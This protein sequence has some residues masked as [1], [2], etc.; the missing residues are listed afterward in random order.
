M[1]SRYFA[2]SLLLVIISTA[3]LGLVG[4]GDIYAN[5]KVSVSTNVVELYLDDI[6]VDEPLEGEDEDAVTYSKTQVITATIEGATEDMV[7]EVYCRFDDDSVANAD[8]ELN[9][10]EST[11]RLTAKNAGR[12]KMRVVSCETNTVFSEEIEVIVYK[13]AEKMEFLN[14]LPLVELGSTLKLETSSLIAFEP[15]RVYPNEATFTIMTPESELWDARYGSSTPAGVVIE[16]NTLVVGQEAQCGVVQIEASMPNGVKCA[17]LVMVYRDIDT[18]DIQLF[19]K[20]ATP[21][22]GGVYPEVDTLKLTINSDQMNSANL[23]VVVNDAGQVLIT[24]ITTTEDSVIGVDKDYI[25]EPSAVDDMGNFTLNARESGTTKMYVNIDVM[26]PVSRKVYKTFTRSYDVE[27]VRMATHVMLSNQGSVATS[28]PLELILQDYYESQNIRGADVNVVVAPESAKNRNFVINV[29][30]LDGLTDADAGFAEKLENL[31]IYVNSRNYVNVQETSNFNKYIYG[32]LLRNDTTFYVALT[33]DQIKSSVTLAMVANTYDPSLPQN[34]QNTVHF[35]VT[36]GVTEIKL[37]DELE[38]IELGIGDNAFFAFDFTTSAGENVGNP[39]FEVVVKDSDIATITKDVENERSYI[40]TALKEGSTSVTIMAESGVTVTIPLYVYGELT[41]FYISAEHSYQNSNIALDSW[42]SDIYVNSDGLLDAGVTAMTVKQGSKID[43]AC[44]VAPESDAPDYIAISIDT[45]DDGSFIRLS[46]LTDANTFYFRALNPTIAPVEIVVKFEYNKKNPNGT[47]TKAQSERKLQISVYKPL[48]NYYWSGTDNLKQITT[49]VYDINSLNY[50]QQELATSTLK[51]YADVTATAL[52]GNAENIVWSVKDEDLI[53]I[54]SSGLEA[55]ITASLSP[56]D[57]LNRYETYVYATVTEYNRQI[58]ISCRVIILRPTMVEEIK[59]TNFETSEG[60]VHLNDLGT[61]ERKTFTIYTSISP[62]TPFNSELGY[63]IYNATTSAG[64]TPIATTEFEGDEEDAIVVFDPNAQNRIVAKN[65]GICVI[66]IYPLDRVTAE[67]VN[68]DEIYHVDLPVIVEDGVLNPYTIYTAEEFLAIGSSDVA[69]TKNYDLMQTIDLS[70][71]SSYL[72]LGDFSGTLKSSRFE[73]NGIKKSIIGI[74]LNSKLIETAEGELSTGLF[75]NVSGTIENIDFSFSGTS[76]DLSSASITGVSNVNVGLLAGK[77]SGTISNVA[78]K[79][80]N[81]ETRTISIGGMSNALITANIGALSGVLSGTAEKV[82]T[83]VSFNIN[84]N[85]TILT[86][87]G[88]VGKLDNTTLTQTDEMLSRVRIKV[89]RSIANDD[90]GDKIGG[91][92]GFVGENSKISSHK[93]VGSIVASNFDCVGGFVGVNQG[94]LGKFEGNEEYRVISGVKT[95]GRNYVGGLV[96]WNSGTI[97]FGRAENYEETGLTGLNQAMA[98]GQNYVGGLVGYLENGSI[99][100]SYAMSFVNQEFVPYGSGDYNGDVIAENYVGGLVGYF[101]NATIQNSFARNKVQITGADGVGGGLIGKIEI[102]AGASIASYFVLNSYASGNI[103]ALHNNEAKVGEL[104]GVYETGSVGNYIDT[105]YAHVFIKL[106]DVYS[107]KMFGTQTNG[108]VQDTYYLITDEVVNTTAGAATHDQ[109]L[110][111]GSYVYSGTGWGFGTADGTPLQTWVR[112]DADTMQDVNDNLPLLFSKDRSWLY[113]QAVTKIEVSA[114]TLHESGKLLPTYFTDTGLGSVVLL[115]NISKIEGE[116]RINLLNT[117]TG[118]VNGLFNVSV[119]P[120]QLDIEDWNIEVSTS[121]RQIAEIVQNGQSLADAYVVFK[122]TGVVK[123]TFRS[124]LD[125]RIYSEIEV[126]VV[127][128][129]N[130]F[131][132]LDDADNSILEVNNNEIS[133]K[134]SY[135][136]RLIPTFGR[137]DIDATYYDILGVKYTTS[138]SQYFAF[139]DYAFQNGGA[140]IPFGQPHLL[141]GIQSTDSNLIE[142]IATPYIELT[143]GGVVQ[144][145]SLDGFV[146]LSKSF[147]VKIYEGITGGVLSA[148]SA[149]ITS[150]GNLTLSLEVFSD[151]TSAVI[152]DEPVVKDLNGNVVENSV[153]LTRLDRVD[154]EN[155][156]DE[157]ITQKYLLQIPDGKRGLIEN[158]NYIINVQV[159]DESGVYKVYSFAITITPTPI[160]HI[161]L[162]HYT[163]G[164]SSMDSGEVASNLIAPGTA[165]VLKVNI[166]PNYSLFDYVL[167]SSTQDSSGQSVIMQ[168]L[169]YHNGSYVLLPAETNEQGDLVARKVSGYDAL[170]QA[171]FDGTIYVRTLIGSYVEEGRAF[172]ISV[173]AMKT[174]SNGDVLAYSYPSPIQLITTFAPSASLSLVSNSGHGD[175]IARGTEAI[176]H[177]DGT[178]L[179]S[180]IT[181]SAD[182][183]VG[184]EYS[185]L[186]RCAFGEIQSRYGNGVRENVSIDIPFYVGILAKPENGQI[187]ITVTINS[188]TASGGLLN[189]I[190]LN[191]T[192][193]IVDYHISAVYAN[194]ADDGILNAN[195]RT[196][197]TL[198]VVWELQTPSLETYKKYNSSVDEA[199][200]NSAVNSIEGKVASKLKLINERGDG[201]GGVWRYNDGNGFVT[202]QSALS[203]DNFILSY[204]TMTNGLSYYIIKGKDTISLNF[205]INF[206][207]YYVYDVDSSCYVLMLDDEI[208]GL[209][210]AL[211]V[212]NYERLFNQ[213]FVVN[214]INDTTDDTPDLIDSVEKFR[215]MRAGVS[216]MLT[217]DITLDDWEPIDTAITSLDG[218]GYVINLRSFAETGGTDTIEYGLFSRLPQGSILKNLIVD[219]SYNMWIDLQDA[220]NV[221]FGFIAGVNEGSIYNCEVVVT[222][223]KDD[224]R[225]LYDNTTRPYSQNSDFAFV[226]NVFN[227]LLDQSSDSKYSGYNTL[228]SAFVMTD[229]STTSRVVTTNVG[230][231]V[232]QNTQSGTITNS[233]VG[234]VDS[235]NSLGVNKAYGLQGL[236]LF[237]SGRVG[238]LV[239][240]NAGA[241]ANSY[242]ANGMVINYSSS[243]YSSSNS[244]GS[245]TAGLVADQT[246][247]GRIS[248]SFARGQMDSDAQCVFGGIVAY[249]TIGGLVHSNAGTI[250]NSYS[251]LPLSSSNAIGGFVYENTGN[252]TIKYSYS[253]SKIN[254]TGLI[255]GIFIGANTEGDILNGQNTTVENCYYYSTDNSLVD[256]SSPATAISAEEWSNAKGLAFD[257]FVISEEEDSTWY[258]DTTRTYL[259]PQLRFADRIN[260]SHRSNDYTYD[261]NSEYGSQTNP[262][263]IASLIDWQNVFNY[264][265]ANGEIRSQFMDANP[266]NTSSSSSLAKYV[267]GQYYVALINDV[268]FGASMH[269]TA[270]NTIFKGNMLGNGYNLKGL[271]YRYSNTSTASVNDFGVFSSLDGAR[272]H[273]L[274]LIVD[275]QITTRARHMGTLAGTIKDSFVENVTIN[276]TNSL[277]SITGLNM[278]GALAGFVGGDSE[279]RNIESRISVSSISATVANAPFRYYYTEYSDS[280]YA[281]GIIGVVDLNYEENAENNPRIQGLTVTNNV[282]IY[283]EIAGGVL[284]LIATDSE[285]KDITFIVNTANE[286]APKILG[287]NFSGGL[288]GEN[289]GQLIAS[290]IGIDVKEQMELDSTITSSTNPANHI[291]YTGLFE[292]TNSSTAIGGLVGLNTG[293][294][295]SYSYSRVAVVASKVSIA[296]GLVGMAISAPENYSP[297]GGDVVMGYLRALSLG[298]NNIYNISNLTTY[299]E[300]NGNIISNGAMN[301]S[302]T[303]YQVYTTSMVNSNKVIGGLV[304]AVIGAPIYASASNAYIVAVNNYDTSSAFTSKIGDS[305]YEIGSVIGYLGYVVS[306]KSTVPV[307]GSRQYDEQT[308][309]TTGTSASN[310]RAVEKIGNY[311][312]MAIGKIATASTGDAV[313]SVN[314]SMT[315]TSFVGYATSASDK[316]F[317]SFNNTIWQLDNSKI[318][319]R[320]PILKSN[321]SSTV[322]DIDTVDKLFAFFEDANENSYGKVVTDLTIYGSDW[323]GYVLDKSKTTI[324][325]SLL[326]AVSG[327]LEGAVPSDMDNA[328]TRNAKITLTGFTPT[329]AANFDSLF[330]YTSKFRLLNID[331]VFDFSIDATEHNFTSFGLLAMESV[332]SN[333]ENISVTLNDGSS[334]TVNKFDNVGFVVGKAQSSSFTNVITSGTT[335]TVQDYSA[336]TAGT[337]NFGALFGLGA[338]DNTISGS[339]FGEWNLVYLSTGNYSVAI[340][341]LVGRSSGILNVRGVLMDTQNF[342]FNTDISLDA[343]SAEINVGGVAGKLESSARIQNFEISGT[344]DISRLSGNTNS[345]AFIGGIIGNALNTNF[346]YLSSKMLINSNI[347]DG[348][349]YLGGVAGYVENRQRFIGTSAPMQFSGYTAQYITSNSNIVHTAGANANVYA[350]GVFGAVK[351]NLVMAN[352]NIVPE[353]E[354]REIFCAL[355]ANGELNINTT[356]SKIFAGG[357]IGNVTQGILNND[358][359]SELIKSN[360]VLRITQCAFVGKLDVTN[361]QSNSSDNFLGGIVGFSQLAIYDSLSNGT[362]SFN[363]TSAISSYLGGIVGITNT[364]IAYCISISSVQTRMPTNSMVTAQNNALVGTIDGN[365]ARVIYSYYSAELAGV[366]DDYGTNLTALQMLDATNFSNRNTMILTNW[367]YLTKET[368]VGSVKQI[369]FMYPKLLNDYLDLSIESAMVPCFVSDLNMLSSQLANAEKPNK[370]IIF[371]TDIINLTAIPSIEINNARKI[372]GNGVVVEIADLSSSISGNVGLFKEI[373]QNV[374]VSGFTIEYGKSTLNA[375]AGANFGGLAGANFGAVYGCS[376]GTIIPVTSTSATASTFSGIEEKFSDNYSGLTQN[377][378][379]QFYL[380]AGAYNVVIGGLVGVSTGSI[381]GAFNN[382]DIYFAGGNVVAGGIAGSL[383]NTIMN[384]S[385]SQGRIIVNSMS[386]L[387][388]IGGLVGN[389]TNSFVSAS[390]ANGNIMAY[391]VVSDNLGLAFGGFSGVMAGI[392][393]NNNLSGNLDISQTNTHYT[394]SLTTAQLQSASRVN[395]LIKVDSNHFNPTLWIVGDASKNYNYPYL[396]ISKLN[397]D[398]GD[399]SVASPYQIREGTELVRTTQSATGKYFVIVRDLALSNENYLTTSNSTISAKSVDGCGN[400]VLVEEIKA[401]TSSSG[402][403]NAGMFKLISESTTISSL[404]VVFN[405]S[406][407]NA[408]NTQI[409]FGALASENRGSIKHCVAV[410]LG[411]ISFASLPNSRLGGLVGVN[412]GS[413]SYS[414]ADVNITASDGYIGGLVGLLGSS[415]SASSTSTANIKNSFSQGDLVV[416]QDSSK[417][418]SETSVGGL[419]GLANSEIDN[420]YTIENSYVYGT[421]I[422]VNLAGSKV[423]ALV[424]NAIKFDITKTYSYVY[425][426]G[427]RDSNIGAGNYTNIGL[428]G[429]TVIG[430]YDST[431][432][433]A[434]WLGLNDGV[435]S[436]ATEFDTSLVSII[437]TLRSTSIGTGC[438]P[439]WRA[440]DWARNASVGGSNEYA[441]YLVDVTPSDRQEKGGIELSAESVFEL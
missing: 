198:K 291:G 434:V 353:G 276:G 109:M 226:N 369:S 439:D 406:N 94:V 24:R 306:G 360:S 254:S 170:G 147:Y 436:T 167:L 326:E 240:Q 333:F 222:Q 268:D 219:V 117:G 252:G 279:I 263:L 332:S 107:Y 47:W 93:V 78:V 368:D 290:Y 381:I 384:N 98:C 104:V 179:N 337:S 420:G 146:G 178:L 36:A 123:L 190:I 215:S 351:N 401:P 427:A 421:K 148:T 150:S 325:S 130:S 233:R 294:L 242:F 87:G 26:D 143:F 218:N 110:T 85:D 77:I 311:N 115:D 400:V 182:Y 74:N 411:T 64:G 208:E 45:T 55:E 165:G 101:V 37:V 392:V 19:N 245:K 377:E 90:L 192:L 153:V 367:T 370:T 239:G 365:N 258:I 99:S 194:G 187:L 33:G 231:L 307:V 40:V 310:I 30:E 262:I 286:F 8:V 417:N 247:T 169:V 266:A 335:I 431:S 374:V 261:I 412:A 395:A 65:A 184:S 54:K 302:A 59:I 354:A 4:C 348:N 399:G 364:D 157:K 340:G 181:L 111:S 316:S 16:S 298:E 134:K 323:Q 173:R 154:S 385:L 296:G 166:T 278:T 84:L 118:L 320:F 383:E 15:S 317:E 249:G 206:Y 253:M 39:N 44:V 80:A 183:G 159:S 423:G 83:N 250:L 43:L 60:A 271:S 122:Q 236:N 352:A 408:L 281:G 389:V 163:Y 12:T 58:T 441:P 61:D 9:E 334:L 301:F 121:N 363:A 27:V 413:I 34:I 53:S 379:P 141:G 361:A 186:E 259:G 346:A 195:I 432:V 86:L 295:I 116:K 378:L 277:A 433:I 235:Q 41:T 404:G 328:V 287:T 390:I 81:Y 204:T 312:V 216:Y 105:C 180:T 283:G 140:F 137:E 46:N 373:P 372:V 7:K 430:A 347:N 75:A 32:E 6:V 224:W 18:A 303:L 88:L 256:S 95:Q 273:N 129:F 321:Y 265:D 343:N 299:T 402:I 151:N 264:S 212:P 97:D 243:I 213:E 14:N 132:I 136:K 193:Y 319:H 120:P 329:Q 28:T 429:N 418:Y 344:I 171:Y 437:E 255:N 203:Y 241:I 315:A 70:N 199:G 274:N 380:N 225:V 189:P 158:Q 3:C 52:A 172:T 362:I 145:Y 409:V 197:S 128:G 31:A 214:F 82:Y 2:L 135:G 209:N 138:D 168:Q 21:D 275:G 211:F 223:N 366:I 284:G 112:Y 71:Y 227:Q 133:V 232:G 164:A 68:Y 416:S 131:D 422:F 339:Q 234:R 185:S 440:I 357:V 305:A 229:L 106:N 176:L 63:K 139:N 205:D 76:L 355:V 202:I 217:T 103:I 251:N 331:F 386:E 100:Y 322:T 426:A 371:D 102:I 160:S 349:V 393:V 300:S 188:T 124:V 397:F 342:I 269:E 174:T 113:N 66:R 210:S 415:Q 119:A 126:N 396:G 313:P 142:V 345:N 48:L 17:V 438:Y 414:W 424:G 289:R 207:G 5:L 29:V 220:S 257:G 394:E 338:I 228:A 308:N 108:G 341:G 69:L 10:N 309:K 25:V 92:V 285:A 336:S 356:A 330:G 304:G 375:S 201:Q 282:T 196:Y 292:N 376:V 280:S 127:S 89:S 230:A 20:D 387:T 144:N 238:G 425:T 162:S 13:N 398:T 23:Q 73:Q 358:E 410:S 149:T 200:F 1:K 318:S 152:I 49:Q 350:G 42:N 248:S 96:G 79:L 246:S 125:V 72:P 161:S 267:F 407:L 56:Q 221:N 38:K 114:N 57:T 359:Y 11:I 177:L 22:A 428:I 272:V 270:Y 244:N 403:L 191:Y 237:A 155:I 388:K 405:E 50:E 391:S 62:K 297:T 324:A 288:V 91:L 35:T 327:R 419:V 314:M 51:I 156:L 435:R 382:M 293:G 67:D 260:Y 175:T